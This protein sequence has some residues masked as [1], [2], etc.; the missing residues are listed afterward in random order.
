M[1]GALPLYWKLASDDPSERLTASA[2]LIDQLLPLVAQSG[3]NGPISIPPAEEGAAQATLP[4][5]AKLFKESLTNGAAAS[6]SSSS[7]A[8]AADKS[9][10]AAAALL[11]PDSERVARIEKALEDQLPTDVAYAV[12]RLLRGLASPR[13]SSRI[14]FATAFT[15]VSSSSSLSFGQ[16]H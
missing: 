5:Q 3:L 2:H 7:S 10:A 14:G 13:Q 1:S 15:Q 9:A 4:S 8:N 6:S 11:R 16:L 12:K